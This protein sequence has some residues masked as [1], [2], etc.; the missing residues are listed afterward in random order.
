MGV[1]C[2]SPIA[3]AINSSRCSTT[4]SMRDTAAS[5]SARSK[6]FHSFREAGWWERSKRSTASP[7]TCAW[8]FRYQKSPQFGL[9]TGE[10]KASPWRRALHSDSFLSVA[11]PDRA[12]KSCSIVIG[13]GRARWQACLRRSCES[14]PWARHGRWTCDRLVFRRCLVD[15]LPNSHAEGMAIRYQ[16][17][18][19]AD[20]Q[21]R[22]RVR[23]D[24]TELTLGSVIS[25]KRAHSC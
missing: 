4:Y 20:D 16:P 1:D 24:S 3:A 9:I 15:S 11:P 17:F 12:L 2:A 10:G 13:S 19:S 21:N 6:S 7:A 23:Y 22:W 5:P 8:R 14:N 25:T 18:R